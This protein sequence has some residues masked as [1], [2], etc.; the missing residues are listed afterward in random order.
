MGKV[1]VH[2]LGQT[3]E[4]WNAVISFVDKADKWV[5][6]DLVQMLKNQ[7]VNYVNLY[8]MFSE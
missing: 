4:S 8:R 3:T 7:E 2:G 6:P 5:C 1:L